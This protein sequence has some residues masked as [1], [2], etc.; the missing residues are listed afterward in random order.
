MNITK[1]FVLQSQSDDVKEKLREYGYK[2][3]CFKL[4]K[5]LYEK[6]FKNSILGNIFV[7]QD[8]YNDAWFDLYENHIFNPVKDLPWVLGDYKIYNYLPYSVETNLQKRIKSD[9]LD[10]LS[11]ENKIC[12]RFSRYLNSKD[13]HDFPRFDLEIRKEQFRNWIIDNISLF[14]DYRKLLEMYNFHD[15][16]EIF[17]SWIDIFKDP[18]DLFLGDVFG[19]KEFNYKIYSSYEN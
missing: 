2:G 19:N 13:I 4:T 15:I 5:D 12:K 9:F 14:P 10:K 11:E 6:K 18:I 1:V 8:I 16:S 7:D 3:D 17:D